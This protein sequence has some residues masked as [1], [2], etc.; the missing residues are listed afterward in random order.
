MNEFIDKLIERLEEHIETAKAEGDFTYIRP[1]EIAKNTV[2]Q[3]AEEYKGGWISVS[4]RL[5]KDRDWYLVVFRE[6]DS[7]FV[8]VPRVACYMGKETVCTTKEGWLIIDLEDEMGINAY[9]KNL[10][11]IAWQ[12]LPQPYKPEEKKK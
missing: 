9:Y 1:F 12:P 3:L 4:E 6:G 2:N 7:D 8:L 10:V 11:C 5:P